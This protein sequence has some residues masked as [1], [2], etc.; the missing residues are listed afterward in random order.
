MPRSA[1]RRKSFKDN[2]IVYDS[3]S[4]KPGTKP[5]IKSYNLNKN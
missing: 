5:F 2:L 1:K 3:M 4:E